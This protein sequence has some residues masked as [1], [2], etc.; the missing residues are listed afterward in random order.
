MN[1]R[2]EKKTLRQ[3]RFHG[4]EKQL[5]FQPENEKKLLVV[6]SINNSL[7]AIAVN[8]DSII[9]RSCWYPVLDVTEC[10]KVLIPR[11]PPRVW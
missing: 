4:R 7:H 2:I 11:G 9:K 10:P 5:L 3:L 6:S 8:S 1:A